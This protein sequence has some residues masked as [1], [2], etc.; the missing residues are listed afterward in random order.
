VLGGGGFG[1]KIACWRLIYYYF[2]DGC[3]DKL[4]FAHCSVKQK[5]KRINKPLAES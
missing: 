1:C 2:V 5:V 3:D 4:T